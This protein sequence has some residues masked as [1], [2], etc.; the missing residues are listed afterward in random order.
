MIEYSPLN[1]QAAYSQLARKFTML[2]RILNPSVLVDAE[3][4]CILIE[5]MNVI[6]AVEKF[7][8]TAVTCELEDD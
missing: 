8:L 6:K 3:V 4:N 1:Y 2:E 7:E 5:A